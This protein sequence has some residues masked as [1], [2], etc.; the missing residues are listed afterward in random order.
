[1][2][3]GSVKVVSCASA[4]DAKIRVDGAGTA[5]RLLSFFP[6]SAQSLHG[7]R[8]LIAFVSDILLSIAFRAGDAH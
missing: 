6:H 4:F 8:Q 2:D 5:R 1:M 7:Q 3:F